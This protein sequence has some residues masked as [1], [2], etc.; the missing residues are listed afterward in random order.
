MTVLLILSAVLAAP[1]AG[2]P[3]VGAAHPPAAA[4]VAR[5][6]DAGV[7][8]GAADGGAPRTEGQR[9]PGDGGTPVRPILTRAP[10]DDSVPE[11]STRISVQEPAR[12]DAGTSR[13][14]KARASGTNGESDPQMDALLEQSRAQTEALQQISAQQRAT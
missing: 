11:P 3:P 6:P 1:D 13:K 12:P 2:V 8:P 9:Q 14:K 7:R 4:Q 10:A 5:S